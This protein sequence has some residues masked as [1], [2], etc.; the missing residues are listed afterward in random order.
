VRLAV[1]SYLEGVEEGQYESRDV[2]LPGQ[3]RLG[4]PEG[5]GTCVGW[6]LMKHWTSSRLRGVGESRRF[7]KQECVDARRAVVH[8]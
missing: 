7:I 2:C 5:L 3:G 1:D 8:V 4:D 6:R